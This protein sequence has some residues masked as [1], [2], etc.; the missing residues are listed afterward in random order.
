MRVV[1]D[2]LQQPFFLQV[3]HHFFSA[4]VAVKAF[5]RSCILVHRS[6][7]VQ[8]IDQGQIVPLA[9]LEVHRIMA[10]SDLNGTGAE[11]RIDGLVLHNR[12]DAFDQRQ[13]QLFP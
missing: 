4:F 11:G 9:D 7:V 5:V 1:L 13:H 8:N 3:F 6:I 12:D 2:L 10:G